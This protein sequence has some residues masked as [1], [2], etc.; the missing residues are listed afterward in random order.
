MALSP[1]NS[2]SP[3]SATSAMTWLLRS[4]DHSLSASEARR[5]WPAGIMPEPG[6]LAPSAKASPSRRTRS[7]TNRPPTRVVNSR[8]ARKVMDIGDG[9]G[10]GPHPDRSLF[11]TP[12]RQ[13]RKALLGENL[14][15]RGCAQRRALLLESLAALVDRVIPLARRQELLVGTAVLGLIVRAGASGCE[16]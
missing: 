10:I 5:A 16:Q 1:Q 11:V 4:I 7:C 12:A 15:H 3:S 14:A 2:A 6:S 8:G 13:G 9:L